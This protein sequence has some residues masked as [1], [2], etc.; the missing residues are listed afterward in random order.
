MLLLVW[1]RVQITAYAPEG[2]EC[3]SSRKSAKSQPC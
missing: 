3:R 2:P 1:S